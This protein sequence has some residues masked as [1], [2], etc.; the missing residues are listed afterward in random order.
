MHRQSKLPL[1]VRIILRNSSQGENIRVCMGI[2]TI[3]FRRQKFGKILN[4]NDVPCFYGLLL[5]LPLPLLMI[6]FPTP[7]R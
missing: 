3:G 6:W 1:R 2:F 4:K 7:K 5:V